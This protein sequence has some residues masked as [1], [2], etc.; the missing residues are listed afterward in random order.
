MESIPHRCI[1]RR[2]SNSRGLHEGESRATLLRE[3]QS[4][5]LSLDILQF[6]L[7]GRTRNAHGECFTEPTSDHGASC[8][9][10]SGF[11][12]EAIDVETAL[13]P[14]GSKGQAS[15][16]FR[17]GCSS[18]PLPCPFPSFASVSSH[19]QAVDLVSQR[20]RTASLPPSLQIYTSEIAVRLCLL[21]VAMDVFLGL[22]MC[23]PFRRPGG[24]RNSL[25][26][27]V[28]FPKT[29]NIMY[30]SASTIRSEESEI[31]PR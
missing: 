5:D 9:R 3:C 14:C 7:H 1:L 6:R 4:H 30:E 31:R 16:E 22:G 10:L 2:K 24:Y 25:L 21:H 23:L 12:V 28:C 29:S 27:S 19:T 15:D 17:K 8:R 18:Y 20:R 13:A 26:Y 11:S